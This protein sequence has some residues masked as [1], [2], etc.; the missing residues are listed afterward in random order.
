MVVYILSLATWLPHHTNLMCRFAVAV[1]HAR[2]LLLLIFEAFNGPSLGLYKDIA[3]EFS[4]KITIE[5]ETANKSMGMDTVDWRMF[6]CLCA[7][8]PVSPR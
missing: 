7:F 4:M 2:V 3:L 1:S 5:W 6:V 8:V